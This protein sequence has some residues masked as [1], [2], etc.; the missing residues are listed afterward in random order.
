MNYEEI[1]A[2]LIETG[3]KDGSDFINTFY[4]GDSDIDEDTLEA[5][6]GK[7]E[8]V[9]SQG[10][11]EGGGDYAMKVFLFK[12]HNIFIKVT[13]FYS[14]YNGTDWEGDWM[15]VSPKEKTITVY[16]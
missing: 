12:D 7:T 6:F 14:S 15:N 9:D 11:K 1:N 13:G 10:D 2:K 5:I 8:V 3:I 4:E 16:E